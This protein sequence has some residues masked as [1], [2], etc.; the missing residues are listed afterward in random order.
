MTLPSKLDGGGIFLFFAK[1]QKN[2]T[3]SGAGPA[4]NVAFRIMPN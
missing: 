2:L 3:V 1:I 4:F